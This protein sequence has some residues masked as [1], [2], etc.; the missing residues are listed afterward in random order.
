VEAAWPRA[1]AV[2]VTRRLWR[3]AVLSTHAAT[4]GLPTDDAQATPASSS[5][6][7]RDLAR[8]LAGPPD[9]ASLLADALG[10]SSTDQPGE[11]VANTLF[12]RARPRRR[13]RAQGGGDPG[14]AALTY[15][16]SS[17]SP[18]AAHSREW[19][20]YRTVAP[21][22][23]V[24]A[25]TVRPFR[26][27][28]QPGLPVYAPVA[29]R[30]C[31]G[32]A[33]LWG[34][35]VEAARDGPLPPPPSS[36]NPRDAPAAAA[37]AEGAGAA[38]EAGRAPPPPS[39]PSPWAWTTPPLPVAR[40]GAPQRLRLGG[41]GHAL[42]GG[43]HAHLDLLG[44]TQVQAHVDGAF[45]TCLAH[46]ALWGR[47]LRGLGVARDEASGRLLLR[48]APD[49]VRAAGGLAGVSEGGRLAAR[50]ARA[51]ARAGLPP[52]PP[53][54][55]AADLAPYLSSDGGSG[56][57]SEEEADEAWAAA[58]EAAEGAGGGAGQRAL[59]A[60]ARGVFGG[61]APQLAWPVANQGGEE[62]EEGEGG[63][64]GV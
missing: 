55:T 32:T 23:L 6:L 20:A 62:G 24:S 25:L 64:G 63:G 53:P 26:A 36:F 56:L 16:S 47:A 22:C 34:G 19:V 28:F 46:V 35:R 1:A 21:L 31:A 9:D 14:A 52:P 29:V 51:A 30:L 38:A 13:G 2:I 49:T 27:W 39:T 10:A 60:A 59:F 7:W 17:G 48:R 33:D 11:G 58:V 15:W 40:T 3:R 43:G 4:L 57:D 12:P 44:A 18:D 50:A 42:L 45:Y 61:W 41:G 8:E 5:A 54:P 37:A